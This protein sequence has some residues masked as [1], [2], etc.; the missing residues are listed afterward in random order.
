MDAEKIRAMSMQLTPVAHKLVELL[1]AADVAINPQNLTPW[2]DRNSNE[3]CWGKNPADPAM[4]VV[5]L[6]MPAEIKGN[7]WTRT[8]A[9]A[10][11]KSS[12]PV[13]AVRRSWPNSSSSAIQVTLDRTV[14]IAEGVQSVISDSST[15]N[16]SWNLG[17]S[18]KVTLGSKVGGGVK[19]EAISANAEV[20]SSVEV[21]INASYS[22]SAGGSH[23]ESNTVDKNTTTTRHVQQS[24]TI[25]PF[26]DFTAVATYTRET[27][28]IPYS[29][30]LDV[31]VAFRLPPLRL[32][33]GR[34]FGNGQ[35]SGRYVGPKE[36]FQNSSLR[37][38]LGG[39]YGELS[40]DCNNFRSG[41]DLTFAESGQDGKI[42]GL[43]GD[44][45]NLLRIKRTGSVDWIKA[46]GFELKTNS[47]SLASEIKTK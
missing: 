15:W 28:V 32:R 9:E 34:Y 37:N 20:S 41:L 36:V 42:V 5:R 23:G 18:A 39:F 22:G 31:D 24:F 33:Y 43:V 29:D 38:W 13:E 10:K 21:A 27:L 25:P 3:F 14:S 2:F 12:E 40:A 19:A 26:T 30:C 17:T 45:K 44:L 47:V 16:H 6:G 11:L 35:V 8:L 4:A 1:A 7:G 46:G